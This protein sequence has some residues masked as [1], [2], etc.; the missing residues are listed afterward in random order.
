MSPGGLSAADPSVLLPLWP[1]PGPATPVG[2][3]LGAR[4]G[5]RTL[6]LP[7]TNRLRCRCATRAG[8]ARRCQGVAK[9]KPP[10]PGATNEY[11]EAREHAS[12]EPNGQ[13]IDTRLQISDNTGRRC[14][15]WAGGLSRLPGVDVPGL[16]LSPSCYLLSAAADAARL[17][18]DFSHRY[19]PIISWP[20]GLVGRSNHR[21]Q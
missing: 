8:P 4:G 9:I 14:R 6:N 7:I 12:T 2:P 15:T 5:I 20:G 1:L 10:E 3:F 18:G 16:A 17:T 19:T 13:I 21:G 11:R